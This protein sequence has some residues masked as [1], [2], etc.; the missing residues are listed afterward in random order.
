M[1]Y[2]WKLKGLS[3]GLKASQVAGELK[4]ITTVYGKL[5]PEYIVAEAENNESVLH[6]LFEWDDTKA[7]QNYRLQQARTILNNFTVKTIS[8]GQPVEVGIYEVVPITGNISQIIIAEGNSMQIADQ[9][10]KEG[11]N[12]LRQSAL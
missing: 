11:F 8:S 10:Q 7:A 5:T 1:V 4:R 12:N 3:K 2:K 9:A 6:P